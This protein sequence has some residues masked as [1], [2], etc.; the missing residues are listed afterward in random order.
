MFMR[1]SIAAVLVIAALAFG[2]DDARAQFKGK[3][4]GKAGSAGRYG[5]LSSLQAGK[6]Q[7]LKTGK[8]MMVV[9]RCVP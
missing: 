2:A 4:K 9:I 8:P 6:S 7:A 5:W 1:A 3:G